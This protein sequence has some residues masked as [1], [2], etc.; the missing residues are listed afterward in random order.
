MERRVR[1]CVF[2]RKL[3]RDE[4][5]SL[6]C[7]QYGGSVYG[8]K[9]EMRFI[10]LD[11]R[12]LHIHESQMFGCEMFESNSS[13]RPWQQ[14]GEKHGKMNIRKSFDWRESFT[15]SCKCWKLSHDQF[16]T[17]FRLPVAQLEALSQMLEPRLKQS[18]N[19]PNQPD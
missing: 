6:F 2:F 10:L 12:P 17:Y 1:E 11:L 15:S 16:W 8:V 19:F 7:I 3:D 4:T 14:L 9:A 13:H 18:S 5:Q